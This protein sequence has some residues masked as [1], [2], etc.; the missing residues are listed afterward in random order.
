MTLNQ[1]VA[2]LELGYTPCGDCHEDGSGRGICVS[3]CGSIAAYSYGPPE[4]DERV[5]WGHWRV[6]SW[7]ILPPIVVDELL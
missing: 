5:L 3:D 4:Y 2:Q 7:S 6:T 1:I